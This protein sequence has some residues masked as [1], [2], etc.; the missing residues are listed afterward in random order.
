MNATIHPRRLFAS[1]IAAGLVLLPVAWPASATPPT[2]ASGAIWDSGQ[3]VEY[4]WKDGN[5]P[6]SWMRGAINLAA[7]AAT[8]TSRA[9]SPV[10]SYR[11]GGPGWIGYTSDI[12]TS[13]AV[14]Y[15]IRNVPDTYGIRLRPQG[16]VLDWGTLRWCQFYQSPPNGCYDAALIALHE[17]GH[18][19]TL[20]HAD[21]DLVTDWLDTVMH[22]APKT[23]A[24]IGWNADEFGRCDVARLQLR[25]G[26]RSASTP[27]STCLAL[28][29]A[30]GLAATPAG[31]VDYGSTASLA[32]SLRIDADSPAGAL[33]GDPLSGRTVMLQR[34]PIGG[35]SWTD[36]SAMTQSDTGGRYV[37]TL[38]ITAPYEYRARFDAPT[39]EGLGA[40]TS[41]VV[42]ISV[43]DPCVNTGG[44][45]IDVPL[46]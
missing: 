38:T 33:S 39:A 46:C 1:A 43:A 32:A 20:D 27:I 34:R 15:A 41:P 13:Y 45:D 14:G 12:P 37:K 16:Y 7:Q 25:Y 6:P 26:A 40:S 42:R 11:D 36:V 31:A 19:L 8:T 22:W 10:F 5:E 28:P 23:R 29:T 30:L 21:D 18:V 9:N 35:M 2:P 4:R 3:V 17:F 44:G 24:K